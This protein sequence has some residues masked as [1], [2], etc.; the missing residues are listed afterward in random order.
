MYFRR[1]AAL[2]APFSGQFE[3]TGL[4]VFRNL[5]CRMGFPNAVA[6]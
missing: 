4:V 5:G 2:L 1:I 3:E 6:S